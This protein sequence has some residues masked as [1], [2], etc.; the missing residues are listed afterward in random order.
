MDVETITL[1]VLRTVSVEMKLFFVTTSLIQYKVQ[2]FLM[3]WNI[4]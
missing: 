3:F 4:S 2:I 1:S